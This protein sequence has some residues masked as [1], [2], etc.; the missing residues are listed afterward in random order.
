MVWAP[1]VKVL[2][3][4]VAV[5]PSIIPVPIDVPLSENVTNPVRL[6]EMVAVKVTELP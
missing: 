2:V 3:A 6:L 4:K 5:A 1:D